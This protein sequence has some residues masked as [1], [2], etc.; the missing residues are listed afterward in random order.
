M[1]KKT[2]II[3]L[4]ISVVVALMFAYN[5]YPQSGV[6]SSLYSDT[7]FHTEW[8]MAFVNGA[9]H[10][11][12][13]ESYPIFFLI[14][15]Y[16]GSIINNQYVGVTIVAG[17][18][19]CFTFLTHIW[20]FNKKTK[21][22]SNLIKILLSFGLTFVWPLIDNINLLEFIAVKSFTPSSVHNLTSLIVRPFSLITTVFF[23]ES[24]NNNLKINK[25]IWFSILLLITVMLKPSFYQYFSLCATIYVIIY[26]ICIRNAETFK[27]CLLIGLA[28]VP[29]TI[30]V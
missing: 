2:K 4:I 27:K 5:F 11:L 28:F 30:W 22:K 15:G 23:I 14:T 6:V 1:N 18:I 12:K 10:P 20:F 7:K 9:E 25:T 24:I 16:I 8:A 13:I 3:V 29:A 19:G 21:I 26:F 17:L